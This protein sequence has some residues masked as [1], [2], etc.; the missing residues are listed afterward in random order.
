MLVSI[1]AFILVEQPY[2]NE[3]AY[4]AQ[5]GTK[6]GEQRSFEYNE[7]IRLATVRHAMIEPL[8]YPMEG[9]EEVIVSH[10]TLQKKRLA[11]QVQQWVQESSEEF[12]YLLHLN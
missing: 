11:H 6:E 5:K 12:R 2:F 9:F 1:Q 7:N 8:R 3:P 4:E 10:F